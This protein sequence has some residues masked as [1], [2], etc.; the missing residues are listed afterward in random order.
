[1]NVELYVN[2]KKVRF[3]F[4]AG[5]YSGAE[6]ALLKLSLFEKFDDCLTIFEVQV[7]KLNATFYL[8][9]DPRKE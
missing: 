3:Y 8:T 1:M 2:L 7:A 4:G 5:W 9:L 6:F